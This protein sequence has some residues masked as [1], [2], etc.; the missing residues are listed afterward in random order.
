MTVFRP[1]AF[2][3]LTLLGASFA[4]SASAF[5]T[6]PSA[7]G[8]TAKIASSRRAPSQGSAGC[9]MK[10][11]EYFSPDNLATINNQLGTLKQ[12]INDN[13]DEKTVRDYLGGGDDQYGIK[14]AVSD[15]H[16]NVMK[17][18]AIYSPGTDQGLSYLKTGATAVVAT[19][20]AYTGYV[21]MLKTMLMDM[22]ADAKLED[23]KRLDKTVADLNRKAIG[24][25]NLLAGQKKHC[26]IILTQG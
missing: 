13:V 12:W 15:T 14:Q 19:I 8:T 6:T 26:S 22:G 21:E 2:A 25:E 7:D 20:H 1:C 9:Q 16:T 18:A 3:A 11:V 23:L 17:T 24:T 10:V 5:N 4:S